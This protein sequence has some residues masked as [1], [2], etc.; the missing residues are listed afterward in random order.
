M[1]GLLFYSSCSF[2]TCKYFS[3]K[4]V[5]I[6]IDINVSKNRYILFP[7]IFFGILHKDNLVKYLLVSSPFLCTF[8]FYINN[9]MAPAL[10][11]HLDPIFLPLSVN[12]KKSCAPL[13]TFPTYLIKQKC[14]K[15]LFIGR[16][17]L[18]LLKKHIF[19]YSQ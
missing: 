13:T 1:L 12:K 14:E 8:Y 6:Y 18:I 16:L 4:F 3:V 11:N 7:S 2:N 10:Y 5:V 9:R 15:M 19:H 17:L